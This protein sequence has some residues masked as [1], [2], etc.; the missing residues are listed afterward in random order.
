M[1]MLSPGQPM[2]TPATC[3]RYQPTPVSRVAPVLPRTVIAP[4]VPDRVK[5]SE[6]ALVSGT[7]VNCPQWRGSSRRRAA[8][9]GATSKVRARP[10][11]RAA[12]GCAS[13][14]ASV[15]TSA[16][17]GGPAPGAVAPGAG[18]AQISASSA[19]GRAARASGRR[20]LGLRPL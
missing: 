16:R 15:V 5:A 1:P 7:R 11:P 20:V 4:A 13:G 10:G 2:S 18:P 8:R 6:A 17:A 14:C 3:W 9:A 12:P 19:A